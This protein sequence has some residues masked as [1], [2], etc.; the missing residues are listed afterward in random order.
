MQ[1]TA[2]GTAFEITG[3][4]PVVLMIHGFG[5]T[6]AMW[7]AQV[8][9]LARRFRVVTYDL[10]GHGESTPPP[11]EPDLSLFA[12]QALGVLDHLGIDRAAVCGFSLG[13]MI[14]RRIAMHAPDRL[15]ALAVLHSAHA[16]TAQQHEAI[17]AR[18]EQAR[19]EGP[20]ATVGAALDRWFTPA[21][22]DAHPEVMREIEATILANDPQVY[23]RIYRVLVE[24]VDELVAPD[25][26]INCPT[27]VMTGD[28]DHGNSPAMTRAIA[29]EIEGARVV[30]L[31]GLRHMAMVEAPGL[32]NE[33]LE[34]FLD[35]NRP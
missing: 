21:Y 14:A 2:D 7:H 33:P 17:S 6:H 15:W 11:R 22:R 16:R 19:A 31:N 29:A 12:T 5:L 35:E 10:Y 4:G 24:G 34:A 9:V 27:L 1:R 20:R 26:P 32:F 18:V 30:I 28:E 3:D 13:G 23:P 25:P 8:P